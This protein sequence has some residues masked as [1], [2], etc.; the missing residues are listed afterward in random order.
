VRDVVRPALEAGEVVVADRFAL[1]TLA[2]Q[3]YARGLDLAEVRRANDLATGGLA[4]DLYV[5]LD[6]PVAVGASRQRHGGKHPDRIE[7]EGDDFLL[8][9]R[10]GYLELAERE[11]NVRVVSGEG[12]PE[13]VHARIRRLLASELPGAFAAAAAQDLVKG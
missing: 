4:A 9:V 3:G 11:P 6:V 5:V 13:Q 2:Y 10:D 1:S 12:A 7:R 8:R